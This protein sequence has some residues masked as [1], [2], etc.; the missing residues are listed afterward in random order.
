MA[1]GGRH[2]RS[3]PCRRSST[4]TLVLSM[5]LML[6]LV[7]LILLALGIV[8][9]PINTASDSSSAVDLNTV[10]KASTDRFVA[11]DLDPF[12]HSDPLRG[13][14]D[15]SV[16]GFCSNLKPFCFLDSFAEVRNW[17]ARGSSGRRLSRGSRERSSITISW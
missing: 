3:S 7:L 14:G 16:V 13:F 11:L 5:L 1:K 6:S 2:S 12:R 4:C 15:R 8:S 9:L 17:E 10:M